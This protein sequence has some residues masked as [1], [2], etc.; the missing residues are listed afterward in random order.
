MKL[1]LKMLF[2]IVLLVAYGC[3]KTTSKK[4]DSQANDTSVTAA[5]IL[6][7][8]KYA[9]MAYGGYRE[10]S[11]HVQPTL[12]HL[13]ED[14]KILSAMG[15]RIIRTYNLQLPH[16]HNVLKA[17][18]QLKKEDANFEMYVMLGAWIDCE[19]A[20]TENPNHAN[21]S[22]QNVI[23]IKRAVNL[24]NKYPE[25]VKIIAVGNEAMVKWA[26]SYY[27]EP[28]IILKWVKALQDLKSTGQLSKDIWITSSDDYASWGGGDPLYHTS[29][30]EQLSKAVDFI[31]IHTYPYHNTHYNPEFWKIPHN[32]KTSTPKEKIDEAMLRSKVFAKEQFDSVSNYLKSIGVQKPIHIG[33]TGWSTCSNGYYG[34]N[35]SGASDEYKQGLYY[36][37]IRDWTNKAGITCFYFEAFDEPWK[38]AKNPSNSENHFGLINL[39][40]EAK[41][42]L[43][44]N[45]DEGVFKTLSRGG[46]S[47]TKTYQGNIKT[48]MKSVLTPKTNAPH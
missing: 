29:D 22:Q 16:A 17:I 47:I 21:E 43:W 30:L 3:T 33:E 7:N 23:E 34:N 38:N 26:T 10:T 24:A 9:A 14:L 1:C 45:V 25:L 42:A 18:K 2:F 41:Y 27:V 5:N 19:N 15:I 36:Q 40:G 31:S 11:R 8:S 37:H 13:T 28:R 6:G 48:L 12:G 44:K 32:K 35:G 4:T 39:Q 20:W 46:K